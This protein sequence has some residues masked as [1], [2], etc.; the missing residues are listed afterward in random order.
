M[1]IDLALG[2]V[3]NVTDGKQG[4]MPFELERRLDF[5]ELVRVVDRFR[6]ELLDE[7]GVGRVADGEKDKVGYGM[8][9]S[10]SITR[11]SNSDEGTDEPVTVS[12]FES[13]KSCVPPASWPVL[14]GMSSTL[15]P[16]M[17]L[18]PSPSS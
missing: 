11:D 15:A 9:G 18:T 3:G 1:R 13:A 10:S 12:P 8:R 2:N 14:S 7:L 4:R 17:V 16:K 6:V 5:D